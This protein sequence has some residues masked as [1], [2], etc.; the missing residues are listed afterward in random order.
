MIFVKVVCLVK[1]KIAIMVKTKHL[2]IGL[3]VLGLLYLSSWLFN[4][5][6]PWSGILVAI[7]TLLSVYA[8][9]E[10]NESVKNFKQKRNEK[11]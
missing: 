6:S 5:V 9:I 7:A 2:L 11:K 10:R 8:V 4:H 3:A 1:I